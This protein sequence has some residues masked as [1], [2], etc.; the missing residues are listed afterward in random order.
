[1]ILDCQRVDNYIQGE[2]TVKGNSLE[3]LQ[4]VRYKQ[5]E[6]NKHVVCRRQ[7]S[8]SIQEKT[9]MQSY[10]KKNGAE[11]DLIKMLEGKQTELTTIPIV[12]TLSLAICYLGYYSL[13]S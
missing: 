2:F 9:S 3:T 7:A 8:T 12:P 13:L 1:M 6:T 4:I 11:H 5:V 10:F